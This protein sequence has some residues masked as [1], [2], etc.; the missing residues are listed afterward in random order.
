MLPTAGK[1][2]HD[3]GDVEAA[4]I[5]YELAIRYDPNCSVAYFNRGT[6]SLRYSCRLFVVCP[7]G[8]QQDSGKA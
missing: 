5:D 3:R 4:L 2:K 7:R 6:L 8:T 1:I